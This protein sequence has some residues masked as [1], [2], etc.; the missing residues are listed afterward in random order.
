MV[1]GGTGQNCDIYI[2]QIG[3]EP[4]FRLTSDPAEDCSPA[5]SPDGNFIAFL[6]EVSPTRAAL[7]IVPQRGGQERVLGETDLNRIWGALSGLDPGF[8]MARL[9]RHGGPGVVSPLCPDRR[10]E[11]ADRT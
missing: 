6:R 1:Y 3:V 10:K 8:E 7:L 9:P 2:K 5:W 4:P 11:E